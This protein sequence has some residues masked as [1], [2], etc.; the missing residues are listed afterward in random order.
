AEV[1]DF[2]YADYI[3]STQPYLD[4]T[5]ALAVV[6]AKTAL[7]DA[8]LALPLGADSPD[9]VGLCFGS[10]WGCY[11]SIER[12]SAPLLA[13]KPKTAQGLVFMHSF[14]NSPASLISIEFGLHGFASVT[15]GSRL[16][17]LWAIEEALSAIREGTSSCILAG[18]SEA[19][20]AP[21]FAHYG[22]KNELS[23]GKAPQPFSKNAEGTIL[24]EG[25]VFFLLESAAHAQNRNA[26]IL[27]WIEDCELSKPDTEYEISKNIYSCAPG[28]SAIDTL[29][30]SWLDHIGCENAPS[31]APLLGDALAVNPLYALAVTVGEGMES[32]AILQASPE[33][34]GLLHYTSRP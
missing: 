28:I 22:E 14:P 1:P 31:L 15:S 5:T 19:L 13:G 18:A 4:R 27:G 11:N 10:C 30:Q 23:G 8:G 17:G 9:P 32:A 3:F 21:V 33:G 16:A 12:F 34:V 7:E 6:T 29:E 20:S 2:E 25:A 26:K 24:G